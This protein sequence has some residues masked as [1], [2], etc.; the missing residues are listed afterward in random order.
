MASKT[1]EI[2]APP[3]RFEHLT[4]GL[5]GP[6]ATQET[7]SFQ[8]C[9]TGLWQRVAAGVAGPAR[10]VALALLL[11]QGCSTSTET[12]TRVLTA[13]GYTNI[14][15]TG[16]PWLACSDDDWLNYAFTA[17]GPSGAPVEG[18]VCCGLVKNCTVRLR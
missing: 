18:A 17:T 1:A 16:Y 14:R 8:G 9:D 10:L 6:Y 2:A 15:L 11:A 12:A 13:A 3:R 7:P 4:V 5:E